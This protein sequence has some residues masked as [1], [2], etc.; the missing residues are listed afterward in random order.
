MTKEDK[1]RRK[2]ED[3]MYDALCKVC[4]MQWGADATWPDPD[5]VV[6]ILVPHITTALYAAGELGGV[7]QQTALEAGVKSLEGK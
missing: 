3:R 5:Q 6:D 4:E 1:L 7:D 2:Y